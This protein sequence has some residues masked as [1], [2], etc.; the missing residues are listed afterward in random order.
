MAEAID[1][2]LSLSQQAGYSGV[3]LLM[4]LE[5]SFIPFPSEV[6][7]PPAAYLAQQGY[8]NIFLVVFAGVFGSLVG[9]LI[10]YYLA[11]TLGRALIYDLASRRSA[12]LLL[13]NEKKIKQAEDYFLRYGKVST[14]VGRLITVIRQ[15]IS[16]P[17]GF[18][19]MNL[20]DFI[21]YTTLGSGL[22][23]VI[24]AALGYS[25]GANQQLLHAFYQEMKIILGFF[26]IAGL[27]L[28][29][30]IRRKKRLGRFF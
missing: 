29:I 10:N 21:I 12:R 1:F 30:F 24:L 27:L 16:I 19:R 13:L 23:V 14:F 11:I 8:L 2:L 15:L 17:A 9:A 20:R 7:I 28:V 4:V 25:F 6:V 3:F 22:W 26:G 18:S 5:S